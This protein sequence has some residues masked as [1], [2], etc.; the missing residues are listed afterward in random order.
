MCGL[1]LAGQWH[2]CP[3]PSWDLM[4]Q[5]GREGKYAWSLFF[6]LSGAGW[7]WWLQGRVPGTELSYV[8]AVGEAAMKS[9][10]WCEKSTS[11][12]LV[13]VEFSS[14]VQFYCAAYGA[15]PGSSASSLV[16]QLFQPF[17]D[18][19]SPSFLQSPSQSGSGTYHLEPSLTV[20]WS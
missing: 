17:R 18:N 5:Q 19:P 11:C 1:G 8:L 3:I 7:K 9:S 16:L 15:V 4:R 12:S 20:L 14:P 2:L 6:S 10:S 13:T